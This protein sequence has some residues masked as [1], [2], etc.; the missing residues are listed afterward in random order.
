MKKL[1]YGLLYGIL[2]LI[3]AGFGLPSLFSGISYIGNPYV[4][5]WG[6]VS[7]IIFPLVFIRPAERTQQNPVA[8]AQGWR[9]TQ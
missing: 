1:G 3:F 6:A 2:G 4:G 5:A 7:G 8:L 9:R